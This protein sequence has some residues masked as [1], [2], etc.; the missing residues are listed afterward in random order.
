MAVSRTMQPSFTGGILARALWARVDLAKYQSGLKQAE[1][2]IIH[3]HGGA[4]NRAGLQYVGEVTGKL[5]EGKRVSDK[6]RQMTFIFDADTDQTYNLVFTDRKLRIFRTGSPILDSGRV[7][8]AVKKDPICEVTS[9]AHGLSYG[10]EI[11]ITGVVGMTDLNGRRF[12]VRSVIDVDN[13]TLEVPSLIEVNTV[14][15]AGW[16][17]G[18]TITKLN[19]SDAPGADPVLAITDLTNASPGIVTSIGHGLV[20]GDEILIDNIVGMTELNDRHFVVRSV[21]VDSFSLEDRP[22]E[23]I[24]SSAFGTYTSGG[25]FNRIYPAGVTIPESGFALSGIS[26]TSPAIVSSA[27]HRLLDG[28]EIVISGITGMS[29]INN[30]NYIV[31]N[32]AT[33]SFTLEDMYGVAVDATGYSAWA[34]GG[35]ADRIYEI[36]TPFVAAD[37]ERLT[38]AQEKDV[39]YIAHRNY[40]PHKLSRLGDNIWDLKA[41]DFKHKIIAPDGVTGSTPGYTGSKTGYVAT[42]YKYVVSSVSGETGEESLPSDLEVTITNDLSIAGGINRVT[43]NPV[44]GATRYTVYKDDNGLFGLAGTTEA[45]QFDDE[46]IT[47]D[48]SDAPQ[49]LINP[50]SRPGD[51]PGAI[52]FFE[53][54]LALG[55]T[56]N[57][58][59]AVYLGQS[60]NYENF[61]SASPPKASDAITFRVRSREKNDIRALVPLRGL[62]VFTSASEWMVSGGSEDFLTPANP[63]IRPQG[64]RGA[65]VVQPIIIGNTVLYSQARGGVVRDYSYEY[66]Q[67]G[68]VGNDLTVLA[69]DLFQGRKITSWAYAQAPWSIVWVVLDDGTCLSLTYMKEHEVW[70]WTK[71]ATDGLFE[72][73]TVIPEGNEDVPYFIIKRS[74]NGTEKRYIER[75]HSR[76]FTTSQQCFFVD[77]GLSYIGPNVITSLSGL[78]HLEGREVVALYDGNVVRGLTVVNGSV[79]LPDAADK[80]LTEHQVHIGLSYSAIMQTLDIETGAVE[81]LGITRGRKK[82]IG[83]VT[84]QLEQSRGL[85]IGPDEDHL[86]EWKQRSSEKWGEAV[87]LFTGDQSFT[88]TANWNTSGSI[89]IKQIDP[90]PMTV[91]AIMPDLVIGG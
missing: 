78:R 51:Y 90:L 13:I 74:V 62:G 17:S 77:S 68:Y 50:F 16:V 7:I 67:E 30:R 39:V 76:E 54:R 86:T 56:H 91:L 2:I 6:A 20:D 41:L 28:D 24:D 71:H 27:G 45:T 12:R 84:L 18:G 35:I 60:A 48:L 1:N 33:G 63:V 47:A 34:S 32:V 3:A 55:G 88:I 9:I 59:S 58:P 81:G 31:R 73:V 19:G 43:W 52:T 82:S 85:R 22:H 15:Y 25:T 5:V 11:V 64:Y 75:M 23:A 42:E 61:S 8:S 72:D 87:R 40:P 69:R 26:Q 10:D 83:E 65:S 4:S 37:L 49:E 14:E 46:N 79:I 36:P 89:V 70:G 53:Q 66:S 80:N 44:P 21:D 29:E 57:N 38:Y